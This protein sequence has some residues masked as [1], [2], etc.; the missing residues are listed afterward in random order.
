MTRIGEPQQEWEGKGSLVTSVLLGKFGSSP[1]SSVE[2]LS[3][4]QELMQGSKAVGEQP[5]AGSHQ[6]DAVPYCRSLELIMKKLKG[7]VF[8]K[9]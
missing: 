3:P 1:Q 8:P 9:A 6:S 4:S 7:D 2:G 5:E